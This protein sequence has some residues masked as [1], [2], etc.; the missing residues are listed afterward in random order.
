MT[1]RHLDWESEE[2]PEV[3]PQE[4]SILDSRGA[5]D[6]SVG[7]LTVAQWDDLACD[8]EELV[9]KPWRVRL[10]EVVAMIHQDERA[11]AM[12]RVA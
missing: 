5:C 11:R 6:E 7:A 8:C 3:D 2:A 12:R 9:G 10:G 1:M 4:Q